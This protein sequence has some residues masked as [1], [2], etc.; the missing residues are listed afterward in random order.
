MHRSPILI[1]ATVLSLAACSR[2]D[3][4]KAGADLKGAGHSVDNAASRAAHSPEIRNAEAD[5]KKAGHEAAR[6]LRKLGAEAKTETHKLADDTRGAAHDVSRRG[7][8]DD[9]S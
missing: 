9:R 6:D 1:V 4:H 7:R 8:P 3:D 2:Y 5:I